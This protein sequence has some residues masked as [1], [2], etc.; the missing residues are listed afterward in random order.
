M[1]LDAMLKQQLEKKVTDK[2]TV[3][4]VE[5]AVQ[6]AV[7]E[8]AELGAAIAQKRKAQLSA[9]DSIKSAMTKAKADPWCY[10]TWARGIY[11]SFNDTLDLSKPAENLYDAA[12]QLKIVV[13]DA[14]KEAEDD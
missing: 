12:K 13:T 7:T 11:E 14:L 5:N 10:V 8:V 9:K 6:A 3:K 2:K 4:K 1:K